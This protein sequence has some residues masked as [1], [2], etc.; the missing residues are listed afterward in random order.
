MYDSEIERNFKVTYK[1]D[2]SGRFVIAL[3]FTGDVQQLEESRSRALKKL[4]FL[5]KRFEKNLEY[6]LRYDKSTNQYIK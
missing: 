1:R 3:S 5:K 4:H 6:K 2:K